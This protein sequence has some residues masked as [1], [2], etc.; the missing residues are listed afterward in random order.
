[1]VIFL[2]SVAFLASKAELDI[3]VF[4]FEKHYATISS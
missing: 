1:M 2:A 3:S 4:L